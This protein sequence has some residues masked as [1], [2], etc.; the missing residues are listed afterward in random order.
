MLP[1]MM[2]IVGLAFSRESQLLG[3]TALGQPFNREKRI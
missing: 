1:Y 2:V 3:P